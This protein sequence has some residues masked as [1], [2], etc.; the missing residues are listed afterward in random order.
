MG[1]ERGAAIRGATLSPPPLR[2]D[3]GLASGLDAAWQFPGKGEASVV[4]VQAEFL[5]NALVSAG[6]V[7]LIRATLILMPPMKSTEARLKVEIG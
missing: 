1:G 2:I 6:M 3:S 4:A 5:V 7:P